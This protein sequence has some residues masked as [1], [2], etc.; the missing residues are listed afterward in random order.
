MILSVTDYIPLFSHASFFSYLC[1]VII[2]NIINLRSSMEIEKIA[3]FHSPFG[4]KFG[5]PKQSGIV[6]ELRGEIVLEKA[7][8]NPDALRGIEDFDYLWLVWGFSANRHAPT[9]LT[10][11]PPRLGG[12]ERVGVFASR[13][14]FRPNGLGLSSVRLDRVEWDTPRGPVLHVLGADLMDG[15]PVYDIKPYVTYADSHPEARSGF[16][17]RRKWQKVEVDIPANVLAQLRAAGLTEEDITALRAVLEEDPRPQIQR[18]E[19]KVYG[20]PFAGLDIMF[21]AVGG[22]LVVRSLTPLAPSPKGEGE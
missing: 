5:I 18:G 19:D 6:P 22:R 15:T 4:S 8:R 1:N 10:V 7:Y 9:S 14:P 16:V 3:T 13:S 2:I 21:Q 17:D 11:R 12:N 20:M